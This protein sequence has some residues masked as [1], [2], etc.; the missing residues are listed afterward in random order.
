MYVSKF[1]NI[2]AVALAGCA[3][4]V[5]TQAFVSSVARFASPGSVVASSGSTHGF[6]ESKVA[7]TDYMQFA[8]AATA[9]SLALGAAAGWKQKRASLAARRSHAVKI[10]DTC[11]GC[12]LCVRACPTDVL[13]MVPATVNAA[14]QVASSPRLQDCVGCKRCE[15][16]CPTDF[17]SI[18]VYL[19]ENEETQYSLGLDL[20]DWTA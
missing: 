5:G 12:T 4:F 14:K 7:S 20:V 17:L 9:V 1:A 18:R 6:A 19:Q 8:G 10:Y 2:M 11:I 15:T 3:A 13:E 16:A